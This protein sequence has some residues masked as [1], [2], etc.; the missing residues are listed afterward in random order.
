MKHET[1][2]QAFPIAALTFAIAATC[3]TSSLSAQPPVPRLWMSPTINALPGSTPIP[4]IVNG[5]QSLAPYTVVFDLDS[6]PVHLL[7]TGFE[8]GFS[9]AWGT[10]VTGILDGAQFPA[11]SVPTM[12]QTVGLTIYAQMFVIDTN[13]PNGLFAAS[14]GT[15]TTIREATPL[16]TV[17]HSQFGSGWT[18]TFVQKFTQAVAAPPT[19]GNLGSFAQSLWT[20][21]TGSQPMVYGQP[22]VASVV[23]FD[24]DIALEFRGAI[25]NVGSKATDWSSDPSMANGFEYLQMR[26]TFRASALTGAR[27]ILDHVVVPNL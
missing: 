25:D 11:C 6:G 10:A 27:P 22:I 20:R 24:T 17:F 7:D 2:R 8:I 14:N 18:G 9:L 13:A 3:L 16:D 5:P 26:A 23:P 12:P 1:I 15:A 21:G 4:M 19:P